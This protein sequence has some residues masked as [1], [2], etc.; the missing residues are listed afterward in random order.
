MNVA[1]KDS[2]IDRIILSVCAHYFAKY[3][4]NYTTLVVVHK[5][6]VTYAW[7]STRILTD[8]SNFCTKTKHTFAYLLYQQCVANDIIN[9]YEIKY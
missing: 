3:S 8:F 9:V 1:Y 4:S 2:K 7:L 5:N 6:V